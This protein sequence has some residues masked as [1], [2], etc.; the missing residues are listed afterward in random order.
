MQRKRLEFTVLG[1]SDQ[2]SSEFAEYVSSTLSQNKARNCL[3]LSAGMMCGGTDND[4]S[5]IQYF[6]L[7]NSSFM[8]TR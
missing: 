7:I 3:S 8:G 6:C 5:H 2:S 4:V 1:V